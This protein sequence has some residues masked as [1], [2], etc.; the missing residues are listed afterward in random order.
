MLLRE[1]IRHHVYCLF[2][3]SV[4]EYGGGVSVSAEASAP[5]RA[6]ANPVRAPG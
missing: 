5:T 1:R 4:D 6:P 3:A 2:G